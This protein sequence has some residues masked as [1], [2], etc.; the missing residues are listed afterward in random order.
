MKVVIGLV[1]NSVLHAYFNVYHYRGTHY[2]PLQFRWHNEELLE[3]AKLTS[4]SMHC[5]NLCVLTFYIVQSICICHTVDMLTQCADKQAQSSCHRIRAFHSQS[6]ALSPLL[7][8]SWF[9]TS[10][11]KSSR[12]RTFKWF[13]SML[14]T[15]PLTSHRKT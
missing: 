7:F 12:C 11:F 13:I 8:S 5:H 10:S 9:F 14:E 2:A 1:V 4:E 3:I 15:S 6:H